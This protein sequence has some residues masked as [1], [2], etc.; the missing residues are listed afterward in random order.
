MSKDIMISCDDTCYKCPL[1]QAIMQFYKALDAIEIPENEVEDR[2]AA[3]KKI[4]EDL[5]RRRMTDKYKEMI[6]A[7][8]KLKE[9]CSK[10]QCENCPFELMG[11]RGQMACELSTSA[12]MG[13]HL[14]GEDV[15]PEIDWS[16]VAVDTPIL[17]RSSEEN[18]WWWKRYFAKYEN[19]LVYAFNNGMTSWTAQDLVAA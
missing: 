2:N 19:G 15:E 12:P 11:K 17:V 9:L 3:F 7:A 14:T 6:K 16:K 4:E 8:R 5:R 1:Q 18:E 13:W 10:T